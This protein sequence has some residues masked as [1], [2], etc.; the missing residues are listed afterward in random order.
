MTHKA[1]VHNAVSELVEGMERRQG[2]AHSPR[3]P[4]GQLPPLALFL[5]PVDSAVSLQSVPRGHI[6]TLKLQPCPRCKCEA[7]QCD[8]PC[9]KLLAL[10]PARSRASI[11]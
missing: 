2:S 3:L 6:H 8:A 9:W 10:P 4:P 1:D 7:W 11:W 5:H